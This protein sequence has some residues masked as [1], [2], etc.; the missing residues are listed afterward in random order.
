[1]YCYTVTDC[2]SAH[3]HASKMLTKQI[4]LHWICIYVNLWYIHL[5]YLDLTVWAI[6][7]NLAYTGNCNWD[8]YSNVYPSSNLFGTS[9]LITWL[10]VNCSF[11]HSKSKTKTCIP[12]MYF[13]FLE[14]NTK[15]IVTFHLI[16]VIYLVFN[17]KVLCLKVEW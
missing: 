6:V 14:K 9:Q 13:S 1:M 5:I 8:Y 11:I 10:Y 7:R 16:Q 2:L 15:K 3:S 12:F 4:L 17:F